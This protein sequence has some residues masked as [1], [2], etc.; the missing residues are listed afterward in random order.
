MESLPT[1]R[2]HLPLQ[3]EKIERLRTQ[4]RRVANE[5]RTDV[6]RAKMWGMATQTYGKAKLQ[7]LKDVHWKALTVLDKLHKRDRRACEK[8]IAEFAREASKG[9]AGSLHRLT[10]PR[11]VWCPR[12]AAQ[13]EAT[14]LA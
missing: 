13:G 9:A 11:A 5:A 3:P 12:D 7:E 4:L 2:P 14:Q 1:R 10:K 6:G 8:A